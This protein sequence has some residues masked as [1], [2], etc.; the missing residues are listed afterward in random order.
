MI[1]L[2]A[3]CGGLAE[4]LFLRHDGADLRVRIE[5]PSD[6]PAI[7]A[8]LHGGPGGNSEEY[9]TGSWQ[10][11]V[12]AE[13]AVAYLDQRGQGASQGV[14]D[15]EDVTVAQ[16]AADTDAVLALLE[17]RFPGTPLVLMGHSWGGALGIAT[18]LQTDAPARLSGWIEVDGAHD[19]LLLNRLAVPMFLSEGEAQID[20]GRNVGRWSEIV[21]FAEGVNVERITADDSSRINRYGFEAEALIPE[22]S[23]EEGGALD[24]AG[25]YL[26]SSVGWP[27]ERWVG[28]HTADLLAYEAEQTGF[29]EQLHHI[30]TPS[31]LLWGAYDFVVPAAL[32]ADAASRMP[33]A[34]LVVLPRSGHAPMFNEPAAFSDTILGFVHEVIE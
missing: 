30:G 14:Y 3:G 15:A 2:L 12:E 16:L 20:A 19:V 9:N 21:S 10:D 7:V 23:V 1:W 28:N 34:E 11:T 6:P 26:S 4:T 25:Y 33:D 13:V 5:G 8:L 32:G 24:L 18:L 29:S 22:V 27:T 17:A 31:L